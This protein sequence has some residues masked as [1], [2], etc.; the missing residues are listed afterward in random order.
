M[1]R[2]GSAHGFTLVELL[3]VMVLVGILA[4]VALPRWQ[5]STGFE[6]RRLR[7][8][9]AAAL[10]YAQKSAIAARRTTCATFASNVQMSFRIASNPDTA[11][12][13]AGTALLGP[14]GNPLVVNA[15]GSATFTTPLPA[16]IVFTALG[17]T[18]APVVFSVSGLATLPVAVEQE[19]G[20]VH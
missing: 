19:T 16:D 8:E 17:R 18:P 6:E 7:D 14:D 11:D 3:V 15:T 5:G 12:C 4:A 13:V 1:G 20:Y 10:R 2:G 9:A